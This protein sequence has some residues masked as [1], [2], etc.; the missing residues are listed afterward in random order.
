MGKVSVPFLIFSSFTTAHR[1]NAVCRQ[2]SNL[3]NL[4]DDQSNKVFGATNFTLGLS[5]SVILQM[6]S[7]CSLCAHY[8]VCNGEQVYTHPQLA[9]RLVHARAVHPSGSCRS[10]QSHQAQSVE[11]CLFSWWLSVENSRAAHKTTDQS[12]SGASDRFFFSLKA[13]NHKVMTD[14]SHLTVPFSHEGLFTQRTSTHT[15]MFTK[16]SKK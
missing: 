10:A 9:P 5:A 7:E 6:H 8:S 1:I 16:P 14:K 12:Q 3:S 11:P 2:S 15:A 4:A 13:N